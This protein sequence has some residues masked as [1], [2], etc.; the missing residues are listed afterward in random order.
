MIR[1]SATATDNIG[2]S[3]VVFFIDN[4][5][6][7]SGA[8][9]TGSVNSYSLLLDSTTLTNGAHVISAKA[10]DSVNNTGTALG[11]S[12]N[13]SNP[14]PDIVSPTISIVSPAR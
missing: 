11:V 8:V 1:L 10:F 7:G 5:S 6:V 13:I 2:T 4:I 12:A 14:I 3:S 9:G